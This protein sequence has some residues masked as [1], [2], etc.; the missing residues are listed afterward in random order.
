MGAV[1]FERAVLGAV[2]MNPQNWPVAGVLC[3]DDF[4]LDSHRKIFGRMRD[5]SESTRPIDLTAV[6]AELDCRRELQ[7]V[8]D[9]GYVASLT[10]GLPERPLD[11]V[12]YYV[13]QIRK[14][15]GLRRIVHATDSIREQAENDPASTIA[16]LRIQL[17]ELERDAARY[18]SELGARI[19]TLEGI[20][21]PFAC[22]SDEIGWVVQDLI[23]AQGVTIIAGEAGSGK[24]WLALALARALTFGGKFL[25]RE[26]RL[27]RVLYLDR[28]NPLSLIRDRLLALFGGPSDFRPWG[29]WCSDQPP[30]IGDSRLLEFARQE[31]VLIVDSMI[32]FHTA[33]ENSATQMAPVMASL[34]KLATAGAS[35]V[36]LHHKSKSETSSYRGSSDIVAGADAAFAL[37]KHDELLELRTIKNRFAAETTVEIHADFAAGTFSLSDTPGPESMAEV[38]RLADIIRDSPGLSQNEV[39]KRVGMK[40]ER[41]IELLRRNEGCLWRTQQGANRSKC[42]YPIQ[43]VPKAVPS[44]S[45]R[46]H[47]RS[48]SEDSSMTGSGRRE[49]LGITEVV[50]GFPPSRGGNRE[51]LEYHGA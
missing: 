51:Q 23:P 4:S 45:I 42:Y 9:V 43:M 14:S 21:D 30:M 37:V 5:L 24:T 7:S 27:A 40:R 8:G 16:G 44:G 6:I 32:R 22:P 26:T 50:P 47:L 48:S 35:V 18:E 10:D 20:P 33:D 12:K 41:A 2:L 1:D 11:S 46:N 36:V 17:L 38:D 3:S 49:P 13:N 34:R 25:N 39:V 19:T 15:A 29:L 31:P 28:E